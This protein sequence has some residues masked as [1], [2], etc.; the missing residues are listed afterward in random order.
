[1]QHINVLKVSLP[2]WKLDQFIFIPQ[3]NGKCDAMCGT[4]LQKILFTNK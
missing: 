3:T 2:D 4:K 1:M